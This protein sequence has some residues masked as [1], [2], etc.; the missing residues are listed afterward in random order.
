MIGIIDYGMGNLRSVQKAFEHLGHEATILSHAQIDGVDKLVLPGV[1][2]FGDGM[3]QL[4]QLDWIEP[5]SE[6]ITSG[7]PFL[8]ICLGM[9][10]VC[11]ASEE[12]GEDGQMVPGLSVVPGQV[13]RFT[14][15]Q[16]ADVNDRLKVP[17]MGWNQITWQRQ[18]PLLEGIEQGSHFYFVHSY[19][20]QTP[21]LGTAGDADAIATA[22]CAY[23]KP[24]CATL[25][26]DNVWATQFHPE[27]SQRVGL[28]LLD[29][30]ARF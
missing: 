27:K 21:D 24:F 18:D 5:I 17:H 22:T 16:A 13:L 4:R 3:D 25:W 8:G 11:E 7:K 2:A 1:G 26:R 10:L 6:F 12:G 15:D 28:K 19:Y 9:Q 29:N 30:F 14:V 23:G 20:V